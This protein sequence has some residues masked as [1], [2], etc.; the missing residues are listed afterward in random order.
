MSK[1]AEKSLPFFKT[2]KKCMKKSDFQWTAKAKTAFKQMKRLIAELPTLT[3]PME[4]EELIVYLATTQEVVSAL[5]MTEREARQMPI[6]F[7]SHALQ[8]VKHRAEG[9]DI[10]YRP[11]TSVKGRILADFIVEHPEDD[12]PVTTT[13]DKEEPPDPWTLFTD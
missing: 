13:K 4:I 9:Y 10:Q 7:V 3:A 1:S 6:Y 8:E 2:L 5:L 12:S 11:R